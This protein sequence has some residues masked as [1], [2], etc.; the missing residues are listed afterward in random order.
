MAN[1]TTIRQIKN[2]SHLPIKWSNGENQSLYGMI[3][4][5]G[6]ADFRGFPFP[7][8]DHTKQELFKSL[9]FYNANTNRFL[10][11]IFQSYNRDTI[12]YLTD[13]KKQFAN[14]AIDVPGPAGTGGNKGIL[15]PNH[16]SPPEVYSMF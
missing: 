11:L 8:V 2:A 7:W 9:A 10:F 4:P 13:P 15:I 14:N 1:T 3:K 16:V 12:Q 5:G 6:W